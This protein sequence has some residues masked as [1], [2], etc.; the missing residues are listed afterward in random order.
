MAQSSRR[1][2][3]RT[4]LALPLAAPAFAAAAFTTGDDAELIG[5]CAEFIACDRRQRAIYDGPDDVD[6]DEAAAATAPIFAR[7]KG[8]LAQ[9]EQLRATTSDGIAARAQSLA[10]HSGEGAFSFDARSTITGRLL[11][12]LLRDA[13]ASPAVGAVAEAVPPNPDAALLALCAEF[14]RLH[15][16]SRSLPDTGDRTWEDAQA[17]RWETSDR[18]EDMR[19]AT[20]EGHRAKATIALVLLEE[21]HGDDGDADIR[22]TLATLR[23]LLGRTAAA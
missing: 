15:A 2:M 5:V 16:E 20:A 19:P 1:V 8:L 14:H 21:Q 3:L 18:I 4:S 9:M 17:E 10:Q 6:D 12:C 23:D 7:M 13:A 22:F 11:A